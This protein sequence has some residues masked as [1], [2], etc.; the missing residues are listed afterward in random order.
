MNGHSQHWHI[1]L[2]RQ[3]LKEGNWITFLQVE[4]HLS[5]CH[6][7]PYSDDK[8][9]STYLYFSLEELGDL[10]INNEENRLMYLIDD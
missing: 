4:E 2:G 6:I 7:L 8:T 5:C 9:T 1:K 3:Q 10:L